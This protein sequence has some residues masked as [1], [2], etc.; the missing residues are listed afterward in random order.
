MSG[1]SS[2]STFV[3]GLDSQL[4][5][6][7]Q[8]ISSSH[9]FCSK[10]TQ[11]QVGRLDGTLFY[12][13]IHLHQK[14][15]RNYHC[16]EPLCERRATMLIIGCPYAVNDV[17]CSTSHFHSQQDGK[18]CNSRTK[19]RANLSSAGKILNT[20]FYMRKVC[21]VNSFREGKNDFINI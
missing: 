9:H 17:K 13:Y 11:I 4:S 7:T 21:R 5:G 19:P 2:S 18:I 16:K 14:L 6:M 12:L 3:V 20:T 10:I 15:Q 1:L 8:I